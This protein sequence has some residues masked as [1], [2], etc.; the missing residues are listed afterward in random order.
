VYGFWSVRGGVKSWSMKIEGDVTC[1][2]C[3]RSIRDVDIAVCCAVSWIRPIAV[4]RA[5]RDGSS[6]SWMLWLTQQQRHTRA[7]PIT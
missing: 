1:R 3:V 4:A 5:R 7:K 2:C 6:E